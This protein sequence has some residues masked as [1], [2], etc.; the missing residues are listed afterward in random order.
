MANIEYGNYP[1]REERKACVMK[2]SE[3]AKFI[4]TETALETSDLNWLIASNVQSWNRF[5][6]WN[7]CKY[8][9]RK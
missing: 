8:A 7:T 9:G 2:Q 3:L 1:P 6:S 5:H 4:Y